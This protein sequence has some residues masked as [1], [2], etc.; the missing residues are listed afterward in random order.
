M[1][2]KK[3]IAV[4]V[5]PALII[6]CAIVIAP[7]FVTAFYGLF[8][9]NGMGAMTL[10]GLENYKNL[11]TDEVFLKS[12]SNSLILAAASL[13]IQLP[14]SL[15]L[16]IILARGVKFEKFFR[17]VY[18]I[19][20]VISSM[21]IGQLWLKIFNG[22]HGLLNL[23]LKS[24]GLEKLTT[25]WLGNENTAF[26]AI[27]VPSVW[28]Y[29]GYHMLIMYAGIK[30]IPGEL[31][32]AAKIDGATDFQTSM[33]ITIPLLMPVIK[34]CVTF[35]LVGS[36]KAFDLVYI[37]TG[38]GPFHSSEVPSTVM[39][40]NL[41]KKGAYGYGSAQSFFIILE[42]LIMSLVIQR[43]FKKSEDSVSAV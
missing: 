11:F 31:Y 5:V 25:V 22:D 39:Y 18:F 21:V 30:S 33:R 20:V 2:S 13:F 10:I 28:Q 32:E 14:I 29:I 43:I 36:L 1:Y 23:F 42:C 12:I 37:I 8:K 24:I 19:P 34:V 9:Y 6:Y 27:V 38:G 7:V 4:F 16:A 26:G 17:T 3:S 15:T 41:F 35:A 40:A